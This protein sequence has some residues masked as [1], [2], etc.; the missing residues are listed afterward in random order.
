MR[1]LARKNLYILELLLKTK[2]KNSSNETSLC[3]SRTSLQKT[4]PENSTMEETPYFFAF[5]AMV[6][7]AEPFSNH[8]I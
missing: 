5:L 2:N 7:K 1:I 3:I 6:F 8:S 4:K